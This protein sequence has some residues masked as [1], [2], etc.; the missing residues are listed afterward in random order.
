[1]TIGAHFRT[2]FDEPSASAPL[3]MELT[4]GT[5][6]SILILDQMIRGTGIVGRVNGEFG[7]VAVKVDAT[8]GPV[9]VA[10]SIGLDE[11][12]TRWW[13]DRVRPSR[14]APELPR[15]VLLRVQGRIR[16]A[17]VLSRRQ[18][19]RAAAPADATL[20]FDLEAGELARDGMLIVELAEAAHPEWAAA[21][22]SP[23][24]AI[25]LRLN[26]IVL[27][28]A[29]QP[30]P[31]GG[32][33]EHTGCDFA[34]V[35][36]GGGLAYRLEGAGVPAAPPLPISPRNR[37]TR[38]KPARAVFKLSRAARRVAVRALPQRPGEVAGVLATDLITG[39]PVPVEVARAGDGTATVRLAAPAANPVLLGS[40]E[41][42]PTLSW[43][44][45]VPA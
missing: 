21:R 2:D 6:S 11:M 29:E 36:P 34:V 8:G 12:A 10:V 15:L 5:S 13:S 44:L 42:Q 43:R 38:Q 7:A 20:A 31:I 14:L 35:Q 25:G 26:S 40:A 9:R 32:P 18:G 22:L 41:P 24:S 45:T 16:G 27:R 28:E 1:M 33:D 4:S 17:V 30:A 39:E 37:W 23:R 19:W 3:P